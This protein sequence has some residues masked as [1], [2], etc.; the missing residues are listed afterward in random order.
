V[1]AKAGPK[2]IYLKL[3]AKRW[4]VVIESPMA[5]GADPL[6]LGALRS[7]A[8]AP[9]TTK[10]RTKVMRNS[11]PNPYNGKN[12][13]IRSSP[14]NFQKIQQQK[15]INKKSQNSQTYL[16]RQNIFAESSLA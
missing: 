10:T 12:K 15:I 16:S 9:K 4:Q 1:L 3:T 14:I 11:I 6:T 5:S 2:S 13:K 8:A 7:S